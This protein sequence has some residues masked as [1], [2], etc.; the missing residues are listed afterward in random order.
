[1]E[2]MIVLVALGA[3]VLAGFMLY[4]RLM[5]GLLGMLLRGLFS[6]AV[7]SIALLFAWI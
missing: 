6:L 3:L 4:P 7:D 2:Q 1:M 5:F